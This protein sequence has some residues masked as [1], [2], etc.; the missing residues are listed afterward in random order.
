MAKSEMAAPRIV[1][2]P[3]PV[4]RAKAAGDGLPFAGPIKLLLTVSLFLIFVGLFEPSLKI[5][6][7]GIF[8]RKYAIVDGIRSFFRQG[9]PALGLLVLSVSALVPVLK[10]LLCFG[11]ISLKMSGPGVAK[12]LRNLGIASPW[13]L[14]EVFILAII[15]LVVNGQLI[16]SADLM[17][18][19]WYFASGVLVS[20]IAIILLEVSVTRGARASH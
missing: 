4:V 14:T 2:V 20:L 10:I 8:E 12:L 1:V 18:G 6:D 11:I 15:I 19:A 9:Q 3:E 7:M 13:S 17:P 16:T 5:Y